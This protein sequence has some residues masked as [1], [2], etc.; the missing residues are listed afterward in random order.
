VLETAALAP[1]ATRLASGAHVP[2][3]IIVKFRRNVADSL[4]KAISE[5]TTGSNPG[6]PDSLQ[7]LNRKYRI[8]DAQILFKNFRK[9][10]EEKN[11]LLK[12]DKALLNDEEKRILARLKRAPK[13]ARIPELDRIY[14]LG[15][16]LEAGQ[17]IQGAVAAYNNSPDVEY[18][19][20]NY[21]FS[22]DQ[23]PDDPLYPLQWSLNNTG[24]M[25]PESGKYRSPP[26]IP[27]CDI[28]APEAWDIYTGSPEIIVAVVDSGVDYRHRDLDD[29]MWINLG[30]IAGNGVDD[31]GNGYVDDICGYDFRNND[32][33]PCDD[34]GHGTHCAGTIAAEGD[35]GLDITGVCFSARI[36]ALKFLGSDGYGSTSDAVTAF[37]YAVENGADI[38]SNSWG[39]GPYSY[40]LEQAIDYAHSQG[41]IMVAS[42]GNDYSSSPQ[43]PAD[44]GHMISVAATDSNDDKVSFSNYGDWVDIAAPGVDI[45]SLRAENTS[46]GTVYDDYTTVLS[47]TSMACPHVA[48]ACALLLSA[49]PRLTC[50]DVNDILMS[51]TD[52]I[53]PG[54]C[55]SGRLNL[56]NAML[57]VV[58][59]QGHI[60]LDNDYYSCADVVDI[61]L[62]DINLRGN[63]TQ[64]VVLVTSGGD[65]ET[66]L[67]TKTPPDIG[68]FTG[69]ILTSDKHVKTED[70]KLQVLHDQIITAIYED[71]NDGTG[72]PATVTDTAVV[73]CQGP[74]IFNLQIDAVGSEPGIIFETNEETTARVLCGTV[75]GGN[76]F[77]TGEDS[78]LSTSHTVKLVG[79]VPETDYYFIVEAADR[80]GNL[81][82]DDNGGVCYMF[83]SDE[84]PRDILVPDEYGT[85]QEAIDH[86]W[87]GGTVWVADG[88]Y[89]GQ[90]NRDLDF[91]KRAITVRS[92]NGP[93]NC[94]IDCQGTEAEPHRGVYFHSG[95]DPNS[96]LIGF[97]IQN[98]YGQYG[99]GGGIRC[100]GSS[101]TIEDC[102][103]RDCHAHYGG[104]MYNEQ[105]SYPILRNC[106]FENNLAEGAYGGG[107]PISDGGGMYNHESHPTLI[108]CSFIA[109]RAFGKYEAERYWP[110]SGGGGMYNYASSP[111]LKN[112]SFRANVGMSEDEGLG[113]GMYN[114]QD[115]SPYLED[116]TFEDN[117]MGNGGGM[118][119]WINCSPVLVRCIFKRNIGVSYDEGEAGGGMY[120]REYSHPTL[121]HCVFEENE[122]GGMENRES[123]NPMLRHCTF[124]YNFD[125]GIQNSSSA[126]VLLNCRFIGNQS[127]NGG[128]V[129]GYYSAPIMVNCSFQ[130][131]MASWAGGAVYNY[132]SSPELI[133]C[134]FTGNVAEDGGAIHTRE[135]SN[136]VLVNCTFAENQAL[137]GRALFVDASQQNDPSLI[138][139]TNCIFWNGGDEIR[140]AGGEVT[141][142]IQYSC[143]QDE[144][145]NDGFIYPGIGNIDD[146]P[147]LLDA[148]GADNI[149]GTED[150]N[151]LLLAGS[152]CLDTG[153]NLAVPEDQ[154]DLDDNNNISE[155][156]PFDRA[157]NPRF[158]DDPD[159]I[160]TGNPGWGLP[161]VD[162]GAYE[163]SHNGFVL[164]ME[165]IIVP[166]GATATFTVALWEDPG[167]TVEV[168]ITYASGDTDIT[169]VSG[170]HLIFDPSN[171]FQ[172]QPVTLRAAEDEDFF[173]GTTLFRL[174]AEGIP[175]GGISAIEGENEPVPEILY[176]DGSN[177]N[178]STHY[179]RSWEDS[180]TAI[181]EALQIASEYSAVKEIRVAQGVYTPTDPNGDR[182]VSFQ[183]V[184]GV[185]LLGGYGGL[186]APDPNVRNW[187]QYPTIL[188]GDLNGNDPI[189]LVDEDL[190]DDPC[191]ADNSYH[192][193][194]F[195][196]DDAA[197]I[198][199]GFVITGGNANREDEDWR[200]GGMRNWYGNPTVKHCRFLANS[201]LNAG[202]GIYNGFGGNIVIDSC[203]F[204]KNIS[205][206]AGGGMY[207]G[208]GRLTSINCTFHKNS[209]Q[210][211]GGG[212][213]TRSVF[214]TFE[215]CTFRQNLASW[216]S[217]LYNYS[218][219]GV[220]L[221]LNGCIFTAN[222]AENNGG[223][224]Y[225]DDESK[226]ILNHCIFS[227]NSA[228][229]DGGGIY[230]QR[231]NVALTL[232]HCT[233]VTNRAERF[234]GGMFNEQCEPI[235]SNN[236]FWANTDQDGTIESSQIYQY[237]SDNPQINYC[238]VQ[239]WTGVF[240]GMGN[241]GA[242]PL[243][244]NDAN[245]D[246]HLLQDSPCI[247][248][249]DPNYI[250]EPN[251]TDLDGN[252]RV[253][254]GDNDGIPV[255]DMGAYEFACTYIGDFD[256]Q[257]DVDMADYAIFTLAWLT[258]DGDAEYNPDCDISIPADNSIDM[259]DL[260]VFVKYWLA[261]K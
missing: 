163:G 63:T 32:S 175:P 152:P 126:P 213:Y 237:N 68:I 54:V 30:E 88:I 27:D 37:Y 192:V 149:N 83:T 46:R 233:L 111:T 100:N 231:R 47:G 193:V 109:N 143:V 12:K 67:L 80:V 14:K 121:E 90:G 2:D 226:A 164:S 221:T 217:G 99:K 3:E 207:S 194:T 60:I 7:G 154:F 18:A 28:D 123:S 89:Q 23:M 20:L 122:G 153:D 9:N 76:Y 132:R 40:T 191:R 199:E 115:S 255:V 172:A 136:P 129:G 73:D 247:D 131:N 165:S 51:T 196:E 243:F 86:G 195:T 105:D 85:I 113:G 107:W 253:L 1:A 158:I 26:G 55:K 216:G 148:D 62:A 151:V 39:G 206:G 208:D 168:D 230:T 77:I 238:C 58:S 92:I 71:A 229:L 250:A 223:G 94:I 87:P 91:K 210:W 112:C 178:M 185:S 36:M 117:V 205:G 170:T 70:G 236:I 52:P 97:T 53:A 179:G 95:E 10:R 142:D 167:E 4:E 31:D 38:I 252:P 21:I 218:R 104:G 130:G 49:N 101:P 25:Y 180:L 138:Q 93:Q 134:I 33:D 96:R 171:Y 197:T 186:T 119:N 118:C 203:I 75:C 57:A 177:S 41:L 140:H 82:V 240:G 102:I 61:L 11:A 212:V 204:D 259:L 258:E 260:A 166:E 108:N 17:S 239:G 116:C 174:E 141:F 219:F 42:A 135:S 161:L 65:S 181:T 106:K 157:G 133:N 72:N 214:S 187:D 222:S 156:V 103:I 183:L 232:N 261:G 159:A 147:L 24:Q 188:S 228:H 139:G 246:Y 189:D 8:R 209:A 225:N 182:Q 56:V 81:T 160:D 173:I 84:G 45:L 176:V 211:R 220:G 125:S 69:T 137:E 215:N 79:V 146:D 198:L 22:I 200:G 13:G 64:Q 184:S 251:E 245:G 155:P 257:C 110:L 29:N 66:V 48:G 127:Y 15:I 34:R 74:A 244:V 145:P 150:D 43:Y 248:T 235:L 144:D 6:L 120:N 19:E 256:N 114:F 98:G 78:T 201:A 16:K 227:E 249:G 44:Y 5:S 124:R 190:L 241:I 224:M 162:M 128:G 242:D 234:A 35:N 254:D 59:P 202:A 50:D 169:I